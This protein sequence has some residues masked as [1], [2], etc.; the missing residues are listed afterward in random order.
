MA[1]KSRS[2]RGVLKI[3]NP[4]WTEVIRRTVNPSPYF[5]L[6]QMVI[7]RIE[8]GMSLLEIPLQNRHLQPFGVVHGGVFAS[9]IDAAGFWA[10]FS[11]ADPEVGMTTVDL[12]RSAPG[13]HYDVAVIRSLMQVLS[14]DKAQRVLAHVYDAL[15]PGAALYVVGCVLKDSRLSPPASVGQSLVFLNFY[16]EG[17]AYTEGEYRGWLSKAGFVEVSVEHQAMSDGLGLISAC[18][19]R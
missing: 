7:R 12:T 5:Q 14:A 3:I 11:Q 6:Q 2:G 10:V 18:K 8:W 15:L 13:G 4:E 1:A 9:L 19:R 16:D 17:G